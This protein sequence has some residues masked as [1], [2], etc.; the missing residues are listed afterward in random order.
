MAEVSYRVFTGS[1]AGDRIE[2]TADGD[3]EFGAPGADTLVGADGDD[4]L[5]GG[6]GNDAL[7]GD[8]GAD[9]LN[10]GV[11]ADLFVFGRDSDDDRIADLS[12]ADGDRVLLLDG[13]SVLSIG[14]TSSGDTT[15]ALSNGGSV[16]LAGVRPWELVADWLTSG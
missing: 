9:T 10:G 2:G 16:T 12:F 8:Q 13:V 14:M 7:Y 11:G 15:V 6:D 5:H 3:L 1:T 4:L